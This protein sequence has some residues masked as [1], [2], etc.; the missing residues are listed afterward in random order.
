MRQAPGGARRGLADDKRSAQARKQRQKP[1]PPHSCSKLGHTRLILSGRG[2]EVLQV[3]SFSFVCAS[4]AKG[5]LGELLAPFSWGYFCGLTA[6]GLVPVRGTCPRSNIQSLA[7]RPGG[8]PNA[9]SVGLRAGAP[10]ARTSTSSTGRPQGRRGG[11]LWPLVTRPARLP[12]QTT[13]RRRSAVAG[14]YPA[15]ACGLTPGP[16]RREP[17]AQPPRSSRRHRPENGRD[18]GERPRTPQ[19][20][21]AFALAST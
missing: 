3:F 17:F 11:L 9:Q 2:K 4:G 7:R 18:F 10:R 8:G 6:L 1:L 20:A 21:R 13:E 15:E 14:R 16:I 5:S 19:L 12:R